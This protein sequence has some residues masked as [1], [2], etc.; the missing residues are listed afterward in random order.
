MIN[1]LVQKMGE[2]DEN[3][4]ISTKKKGGNK[5]DK[6]KMFNKFNS[7]L[8]NN[9]RGENDEEE[10]FLEFDVEE[11]ME[12]VEVFNKLQ[13]I[14]NSINNLKGF[15]YYKNL[16][17]F[18]ILKSK[19]SKAFKKN[20]IDIVENKGKRSKMGKLSKRFYIL[21]KNC[22][23]DR[24]KQCDI[25]PSYFLDLKKDGWNELLRKHNIVDNED[26]GDE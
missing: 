11:N 13:T 15:P 5:A 24:W 2:Q 12:E 21:S 26:S 19:N 14:V 17:N 22:A 9:I 8:I 7:F 20:L 18:H 16:I 3:S 25:G 10:T 23:K 4:T 6:Q 1:Q